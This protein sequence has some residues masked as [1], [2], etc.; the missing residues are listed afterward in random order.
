MHGDTVASPLSENGSVAFYAKHNY[1]VKYKPC[2]QNVLADAL[3]RRPDY[4]LAQV[5]TPSFHIKKLIRVAYPRYPRCVALVHAIK[6]TEHRDSD[7]NLSARLRAIL[8][9]YSIDNGF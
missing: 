9:R 2:K 3:S 4:D 1:K 7:S 6:S 8:H 5:M